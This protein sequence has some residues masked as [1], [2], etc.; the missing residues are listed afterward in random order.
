MRSNEMIIEELDRHVRHAALIYST[1]DRKVRPSENIIQVA[2]ILP[3]HAQMI[4]VAKLYSDEPLMALMEEGIA[5]LKNTIE[6]I[7]K[8]Q[9][10]LRDL[11]ID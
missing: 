1:I 3:V 5:I 4:E 7:F 8:L 11:S 6:D 10:S 9:P 2:A